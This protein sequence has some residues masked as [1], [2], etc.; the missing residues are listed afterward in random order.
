MNGAQDPTALPGEAAIAAQ[1]VRETA[2]R[3]REETGRDY[4]RGTCDENSLRLA[5]ALDDVGFAAD[6]VWG[7][8]D[9]P[10][11]NDPKTVADAYRQAVVHVWIEVEID[12][13]Q[14]VAE[15]AAETGRHE[16][17]PSMRADRPEEYRVIDRVD[18]AGK[19]DGNSLL[20]R[21][22]EMNE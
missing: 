19:V 12:G 17:Q 20:D 3:V 15:L 4:L 22:R 6:V 10:T 8:V 11:A 7:W 2:R 13:H 9:V 5:A 18:Y 21:Y 16:G 14:W 1:V